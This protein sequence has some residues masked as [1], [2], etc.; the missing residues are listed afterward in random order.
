MRPP[1]R[2]TCAHRKSSSVVEP[3]P[4]DICFN[5]HILD[6]IADY[7][8]EFTP[9]KGMG[10]RD[11]DDTGCDNND[12]DD[13]TADE[14]EDGNN[15]HKIRSDSAQPPSDRMPWDDPSDEVVLPS[16]QLGLHSYRIRMAEPSWLF[17]DRS[18]EGES[19]KCILMVD[20]G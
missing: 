13:D 18:A 20:F 17:A 14:D 12:E 3:T 4:E 10:S 1:S 6:D 9:F 7:P 11:D 5:H 8:S 19:L 16:N 15:S 2:V